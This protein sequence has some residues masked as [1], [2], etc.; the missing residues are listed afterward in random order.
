[1]AIMY[2]VGIWTVG[3]FVGIGMGRWMWRDDE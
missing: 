1:M 3:F 2:A